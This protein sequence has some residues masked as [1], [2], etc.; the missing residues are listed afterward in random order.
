MW[1]SVG[2]ECLADANFITANLAMDQ[3]VDVMVEQYAG[4]PHDF[5]LL[6]PSTPSG[7]TCLAHWAEF[8]CN[9]VDNS[10]TPIGS[11]CKVID[12][13]GTARQLQ[14]TS[15]IPKMAIEDIRGGMAAQI[16]SWNGGVGEFNSNIN[17]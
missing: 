6:F 15:M 10:R 17:I 4:M 3:G 8:M 2:E 16:R 7:Q 12:L 13:S 11:V 14:C 9:A 1:F 5:L